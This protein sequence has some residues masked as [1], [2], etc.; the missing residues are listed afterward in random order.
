MPVLAFSP[1]QLLILSTCALTEPGDRSPLRRLYLQA[2]TITTAESWR[3]TLQAFA[4]EKMVVGDKKGRVR[5][6]KELECLIY[7]LHR[8]EEAI[9]FS[10]FGAPDIAES[11]FSRSGRTWVH[12]AINFNE[13]LEVVTYPLSRPMVRRWF[14]D[15]LL[16]DVG[17]VPGHLP[18]AESMTLSA[19]ELILLTSAQSIY[20]KRV[21]TLG[22][23]SEDSLRITVKELGAPEILANVNRVSSL[24][25]S[26]EKL[27]RYMSD[28]DLLSSAERLLAEKNLVSLHGEN[29]FSFTR[30][31]M[32]LFDPGR[33]LGI[34][35]AKSFAP[36]MSAKILY[37]YGD[38]ALLMEPSEEMDLAVR[39]IPFPCGTAKED[40]FE[41][42]MEK[43]TPPPTEEKTAPLREEAPV[44]PLAATVI[45][46]EDRIPPILLKVESGPEAGKVYRF[47]DEITMGRDPA[48]ALP[49]PD[50][51]ASRRHAVLAPSALGLWMLRDLASSNGTFVNGKR[52]EGPTPL[53]PGDKIRVGDTVLLVQA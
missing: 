8:P 7:L 35:A 42:V 28:P 45:F 13:T 31:S 38:G 12:L 52:I 34:V 32:A 6:A 40:L 44:D 22:G 25:L 24:F 10:R 18:P 15:E 17:F 33:I 20:G 2:T 49:L 48:N 41:R 51:R 47:S 29:S 19:P 23:L 14:A 53:K 4:D 1:E 50:P 36:V 21:E 16:G 30:L 37:L 43:L 46:G 9:S 39:L 5:L 11:F 27:Q 3:E 26:P